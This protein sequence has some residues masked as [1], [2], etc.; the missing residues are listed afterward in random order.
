MSSDFETKYGNYDSFTKEVYFF[1]L[2]DV[3][4]FVTIK[5]LLVCHISNKELPVFTI[6]RDEKRRGQLKSLTGDNCTGRYAGAQAYVAMLPS[7]TTAAC[8]AAARCLGIPKGL[9]KEWELA[10]HAALSRVTD[11]EG[12][13]R[14]EEVIIPYLPNDSAK[15]GLTE[16]EMKFWNAGRSETNKAILAFL[17][18][19]VA[20]TP[21]WA[22]LGFGSASFG[23]KD[24][25]DIDCWAVRITGNCT[26]EAV[27]EVLKKCSA[28]LSCTV[29]RTRIGTVMHMDDVIVGDR[30]WKV[31]IVFPKDG[32]E[33]LP[34]MARKTI[35]FNK[36]FSNASVREVF[37]LVRSRVSRSG[38]VGPTSGKIN[39]WSSFLFTFLY[40]CRE[41][42]VSYNPVSP[43]IL[44]EARSVDI[45]DPRTVARTCVIQFAK[46]LMKEDYVIGD[47]FAGRNSRK[48]DSEFKGK[49]GERF[50]RDPFSSV[51]DN[52]LRTLTKDKLYSVVHA[53]RHAAWCDALK[54][55]GK[56]DE[57]FD[58][59]DQ[60][61][62]FGKI[63]KRGFVE[64]Q[65]FKTL[66]LGRV[67]L[68]KVAGKRAF[69]ISEE[70]Q[71]ACDRATHNSTNNYDK[72]NLHLGPAFQ[73]EM[74]GVLCYSWLI[75]N[76]KYFHYTLSKHEGVVDL[77]VGSCAYD[78]HEEDTELRRCDRSVCEVLLALLVEV[79]PNAAWEKMK[80]VMIG[81]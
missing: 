69:G 6:E 45:Q 51:G 49:M 17:A 14:E 40:L 63:P 65:G 39:M 23:F 74:K 57:D 81:E 16:E 28:T 38:A 15:V 26:Q 3:A 56:E 36:L 13:K 79:Q 18:S 8:L 53:L 67:V 43:I 27:I 48:S 52:P 4:A 1:N 32:V 66:Q 64:P 80:K 20:S 47:L 19:R 30:A 37:T 46:E 10:I 42:I 78:A 55:E 61:S 59:E 12:Q 73:E 11:A 9:G 70:Y 34:L 21:G 77:T 25:N 5:E 60:N 7:G 22:V 31:D 76:F 44:S 2:G 50:I 75:E 58:F 54:H 62:M 33:L 41:S 71:E 35:Y 24:A 29:E 68:V 72:T